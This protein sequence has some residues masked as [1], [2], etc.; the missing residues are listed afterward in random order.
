MLF[1]GTQMVSL[2][3]GMRLATDVYLPEGAGPWP[4]ILMRTPYLR[5]S[6]R[7]Q[8][9]AGIYTAHGFAV[10]VQDVR[11][12]GESVS[13]EAFYPW[14]AER[15]DGQAVLR[16]L[17]GRPFCN[18]RV[19]THGGSYLAIDQWLAA[20]DAPDC[21]E[22]MVIYAG[23]PSVYE[24]FYNGGVHHLGVTLPYALLMSGGVDFSRGRAEGWKEMH[25]RLWHLPLCDAD[26]V[27]GQHRP[28]FQ[29]MIRTPADDPYWRALDG[30]A[31]PARVKVPVLQL[32]GWFDLY[33]TQSLRAWE[34]LR[35]EAGSQEAR[36]GSRI[37]IGAWSHDRA[38]SRCGALDFGLN[39]C[40]DLYWYEIRFFQHWLMDID[41]GLDQEPP[42]RLFTMG[43]NTW[44]DFPAWPPPDA[45]LR[46]LYL[47]S[48]G[49]ANTRGGDGVLAWAQPQQE[50]ADQ[51]RYDPLDPAP[52]V[53]GNHSY[54]FAMI[55]A[56]PMDH[57]AVEDRSDVLVYT[58]PV[59]EGPMEIAGP[60]QLRLFAASNARDTDF[61]ATLVDVQPDGRPLNISEGAVRASCRETVLQP[62]LIEPGRVYEY[63]IQLV[64]LSHVFLPGHRIRLEVSSSN[65]PKYSRNLNTGEDSHTTSRTQVAEQAVFH[66]SRYPSALMLW[67]RGR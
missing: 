25:K 48:G 44:Q 62:T 64:D 32:D 36:E 16:W 13:P 57:D 3:D 43:A 28:F 52:T 27:D 15:E 55:P 46:P 51:Y 61:M 65:F 39:V 66:T 24:C 21:L 40:L 4:A 37:L 7:Y 29:D 31:D 9:K 6:D 30:L 38:G 5:R 12:T 20:P 22:C 59:L 53:G 26:L 10:V 1:Q 50:L 19:G 60:V 8:K 49:H 42:V 35:R 54:D 33:P 63:T 41:T 58:S 2:P 45:E 23:A 17:A 18:G 34:T 67:L 56:G 14:K 47:H 11:G